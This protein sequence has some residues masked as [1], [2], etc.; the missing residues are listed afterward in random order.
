VISLEIWEQEAAA[1]AETWPWSI[2][3]MR[4]GP[5]PIGTLIRH[6]TNPE[7]I[8]VQS[9]RR[10]FPPRNLTQ[11]FDSWLDLAHF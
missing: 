5:I 1:A 6:K 11:Q 3:V 9:A 10:Y 2:F 8:N 7:W 4:A